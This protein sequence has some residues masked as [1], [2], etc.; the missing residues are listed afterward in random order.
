MFYR[1]AGSRKMRMRKSGR[2][3]DRGGTRRRYKRDDL[4]KDRDR[5]Y[6]WKRD[7][8]SDHTNRWDWP[9]G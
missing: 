1:R 6:K 3:R 5:G 2:R 4:H 9:K 8:Y 7:D